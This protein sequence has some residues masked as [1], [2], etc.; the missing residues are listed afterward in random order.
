MSDCTQAQR[1][2]ADEASPPR[3][4]PS[5][6]G[7]ASMVHLIELLSEQISGPPDESF[8]VCVEDRCIGRS[9]HIAA[10]AELCNCGI[11]E[12]KIDR[13]DAPFTELVFRAGDLAAFNRPQDC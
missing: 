5:R 12:V 11:N 2:L 1:R 3:A 7:V 4:P 6:I 13:F 8:D 9:R 10:G